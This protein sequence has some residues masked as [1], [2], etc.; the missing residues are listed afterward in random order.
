[1]SDWLQFGVILSYALSYVLIYL[2]DKAHRLEIDKI[3]ETYQAERQELLDRIMA[4]NIHEFK[5]ATGALTTKRSETG[6]FLKDRMTK[7]IAKQFSE[8]D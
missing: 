8:L 5:S 4:N 3:H 2:K 6:N 7:E 1:M